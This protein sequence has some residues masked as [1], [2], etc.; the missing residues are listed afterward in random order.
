M[1]RKR[2][3]AES[4]M[5]NDD[6]FRSL[7]RM[8]EEYDR[9]VSPLTK[10]LEIY[11]RWHEIMS[12]ILRVAEMHDDVL[13]GVTAFD[14]SLARRLSIM[15]EPY[16][17]ML[18]N[19]AAIENMMGTRFSELVQPQ[20]Y[21]P[22]IASGLTSL[23][24]ASARLGNEVQLSHAASGVATIAEQT[25]RVLKPWQTNLGVISNFDTSIDNS[26]FGRLVGMEKAVAGLSVSVKP[27]A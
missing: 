5:K 4:N 21:V 11:D 12:P 9:I 7:S 27:C 8:A 15:T 17:P 26:A 22:G 13:K 14:T 25:A 23:A 19:M 18:D 3:E 20:I 6:M 2:E 1:Q 16:K 24:S 10:Q